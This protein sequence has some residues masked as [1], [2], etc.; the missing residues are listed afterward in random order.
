M[1]PKL[2]SVEIT[3][4]ILKRITSGWFDSS[5]IDYFVETF[6]VTPG[7]EK[8]D[9]IQRFLALLKSAP[10][11]VMDQETREKVLEV[12]QEYIDRVIEEESSLEEEN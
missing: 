9:F 3:Y 10:Q 2:N 12:G 4:E 7:K 11:T 5:D 6:A 8:V 1:R